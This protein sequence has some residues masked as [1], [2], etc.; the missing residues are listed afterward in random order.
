MYKR[1]QART[2]RSTRKTSR[3]QERNKTGDLHK[4]LTHK[5]APHTQETK[6]LVHKKPR[7]SPETKPRDQARPECGTRSRSPS[8]KNSRADEDPTIT[9]TDTG[10]EQKSGDVQM[11]HAAVICSKRQ[12]AVESI[13]GEGLCWRRECGAEETTRCGERKAREGGL[14]SEAK[15]PAENCKAERNNPEAARAVEVEVEGGGRRRRGPSWWMLEKWEAVE[16]R[17]KC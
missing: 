5:R 12:I 2:K 1:T 13:R 8:P 3:E 7:K 10:E 9:R 4:L 14:R 15:T 6:I 11:E 17:P 16:K